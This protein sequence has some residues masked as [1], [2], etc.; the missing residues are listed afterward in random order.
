MIFR[1]KILIIA[2]SLF[3]FLLCS[4]AEEKDKA[5]KR[6]DVADKI[7]ETSH[8]SFNYYGLLDIKE[9]RSDS[10]NGFW[11]D[12]LDDR[13]QATIYC[14][15]LSIDSANLY[16]TLEDSYHLAYSHVSVA[17]GINQVQL[18]NNDRK[19][20]ASIYEIEGQVATPIQFFVTDS[21]RHFLRGS[22]YYNHAVKMD[23]V[24][25]MTELLRQDIIKLIETLN[26]K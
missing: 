14:T 3:S 1:S 20:Y 8:F 7:F 21:V 19:T 11:F 6:V 22:L 10:Q 15:Y 9:K 13:L 24:A 23:S 12:I 25:P 18:K 16:K 4:C 26:W 2:L 17:E 5:I